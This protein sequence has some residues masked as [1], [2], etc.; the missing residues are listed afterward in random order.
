MQVTPIQV[1]ER[2]SHPVFVANEFLNDEN[3]YENE[4]IVRARV[5]FSLPIA[6]CGGERAPRARVPLRVFC[7]DDATAGGGGGRGRQLQPAPTAAATTTAIAT[8]AARV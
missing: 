7:G 2:N 5:Y 1:H 3:D 6:G 8:A 4:T